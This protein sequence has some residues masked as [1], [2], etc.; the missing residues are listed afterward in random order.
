MTKLLEQDN[1]SLPEG[2]R[3]TD[4]GSKSDDHE[5][6]HVLKAVF[7]KYQDFLIDYGASNHMVSSKESFYS[8]NIIDG[9]STCMGEYT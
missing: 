5:R 3:K 6:F 1:I 4:S 8:L 2:T 9:P 7:F